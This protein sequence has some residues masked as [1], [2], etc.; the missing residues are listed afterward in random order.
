VGLTAPLRSGGS[1]PTAALADADAVT[2]LRPGRA[3]LND[4]QQVELGTRDWADAALTA[5]ATVVSAR[6]S[7]VVLDAGSTTLGADQPARA[8]SGRRLPDHPDAR[9]GALSNTTPPSDSAT[10]SHRLPSARG[11]APNHVCA[12]V[13]PADQLSAATHGQ[14]EPWPVH[15]RGA[16]T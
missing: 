4:A 12:E 11:C 10:A 14:L 7:R 3:A 9:I 15:A 6:S 13:S 16:T 1:T 8:A 2:E 5:V